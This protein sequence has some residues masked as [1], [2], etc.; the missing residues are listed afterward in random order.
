MIAKHK[1]VSDKTE[2]FV[3]EVLRTHEPY[4]VP[5]VPASVGYLR[6]LFSAAPPTVCPKH[7]RLAC[8]YCVV[9]AYAAIERTLF[10]LRERRDL[11]KLTNYERTQIKVP[12]G[13]PE[14]N[15]S[16]RGYVRSNDAE[17]RLCVLPLLSYL[18]RPWPVELYSEPDDSKAVDEPW[19]S[20][21]SHKK[22]RARQAIA[23]AC[24]QWVRN[25]ETTIPIDWQLYVIHATR[26]W[27]ESKLPYQS[28]KVSAE[29]QNELIVSIN[30]PADRRVRPTSFI[31][32]RRSLLSKRRTVRHAI[33]PGMV[34]PWIA[35]DESSTAASFAPPQSPLPEPVPFAQPKKHPAN[36]PMQRRCTACGMINGHTYW[37]RHT[38]SHEMTKVDQDTSL[39]GR[40]ACVVSRDVPVGNP[41]PGAGIWKFYSSGD[42][43]TGRDCVRFVEQR[44]SPPALPLAYV[45]GQHGLVRT[46]DREFSDAE[47]RKLEKKE[48]KEGFQTEQWSRNKFLQNWH[49]DESSGKRWI[50]RTGKTATSETLDDREVVD[51]WDGEETSDA[52]KEIVGKELIGRDEF[53]D[54]MQVEELADDRELEEIAFNNYSDSIHAHKTNYEHNNKKW[55]KTNRKFRDEVAHLK[56]KAFEG[57]GKK[58][59]PIRDVLNHPEVKV[60]VRKIGSNLVEIHPKSKDIVDA[61]IRIDVDLSN[62]EKAEKLGTTEGALKKQQSRIKQELANKMEEAKD[63][64]SE[65]FMAAIHDKERQQLED[66]GGIFILVR[67]EGG[68][69]EVYGLVYGEVPTD[70]VDALLLIREN[71]EKHMLASANLA[72][73]KAAHKLRKSGVYDAQ[74]LSD[75]RYGAML[76]VKHS[77]DNADWYAL[78]PLTPITLQHSKRNGVLA[79]L[80]GK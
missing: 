4:C 38:R 58:L 7:A 41:L 21:D 48:A 9:E 16:Q 55:V 17:E 22:I 60:L 76:R 69:S 8:K 20:Y 34:Q 65:E 43:K 33:N 61:V 59:A 54:E 70:R 78:P 28:R 47:E 57:A 80:A 11:C 62:R 56:D 53:S 39:C 15:Q 23:V 32:S 31:V 74:Q 6:D 79:G 63:K 18:W 45:V 52:N 35:L 77:F 5:S 50:V 49:E 66:Y 27:L 46:N 2:E 10:E 26:A 42:Y 14:L 12:S 68:N 29:N 13:S 40:E 64:A 30:N 37:N 1:L 25:F 71:W 73:R 67:H 19:G 44:N 24:L 51:A 75:A 36:W 3:A 72:G